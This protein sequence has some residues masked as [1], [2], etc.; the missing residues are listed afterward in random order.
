MCVYIHKHI[1][2]CVC[3]YVYICICVYVSGVFRET[4]PRFGGYVSY[5]SGSVSWARFAPMKNANESVS[6]WARKRNTHVRM[7]LAIYV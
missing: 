5:V 7:Y 2:M 3:V 6:G 1:Y 4:C